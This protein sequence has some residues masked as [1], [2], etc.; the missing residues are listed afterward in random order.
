MQWTLQQR[1]KDEV[2]V[3]DVVIRIIIIDDVDTSMYAKGNVGYVKGLSYYYLSMNKT[4][5]V[6]SRLADVVEIM[7]PSTGYD[8]QAYV[9]YVHNELR[10]CK[11][12]RMSDD[13]RPDLFI[14]S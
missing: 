8:D 11:H 9:S 7:G 12:Y 6:A 1:L 13:A 14:I 4:I 3:V 10:E 5:W 2:L